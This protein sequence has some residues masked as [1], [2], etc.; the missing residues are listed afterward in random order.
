[1]GGVTLARQTREGPP[2]LALRA[3]VKKPETGSGFW[4]WWWKPEPNPS[5][6]SEQESVR[7]TT[8]RILPHSAISRISGETGSLALAM[9]DA[10]QW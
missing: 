4:D 5:P 7:Q 10:G 8:V 2:A 9:F 6:I 3:D 1:M